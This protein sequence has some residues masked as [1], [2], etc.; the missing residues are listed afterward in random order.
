MMGKTGIGNDALKYLGL[1]ALKYE[2]LLLRA[3]DAVSCVEELERGEIDILQA[4]HLHFQPLG[5]FYSF[6]EGD[7]KFLGVLNRTAF[8]DGENAGP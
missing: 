1:G 4:L 8:L 3:K 7:Q 6:G 5:F 2:L